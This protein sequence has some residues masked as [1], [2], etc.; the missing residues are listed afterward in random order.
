MTVSNKTITDTD[1]S[2]NGASSFTTRH[3]GG[4]LRKPPQAIELA[5]LRR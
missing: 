3:S 1:N 2:P 5:S 4:H